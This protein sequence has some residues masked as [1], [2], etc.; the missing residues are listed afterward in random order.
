MLGLLKDSH[1][2]FLFFI[3]TKFP[4]EVYL[5]TEPPVLEGAAIGRGL[6]EFYLPLPTKGDGRWPELSP[7]ALRVFILF[8]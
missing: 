3:K 4:K 6:I 7:F 5:W 2:P 1:F 8:Q